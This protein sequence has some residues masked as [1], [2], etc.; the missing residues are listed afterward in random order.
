MATLQEVQTQIAEVYVAT[1]NRAPDAAGL[2]YW[3]NHILN[4]NWTIAQVAK[5]MFQSSEVANTYPSSMNNE[6]FLKAIYNNVLGRDPDEEGLSY[7]LEQ[8][9]NGLSK[10]QM[11]ITVINGA[12]ASTGSESD[13]V[14][15]QNKTD[16][17]KYFAIDLGLD[18][19]Y[20]ARKVVEYITTDSLTLYFS[21]AIAYAL[22]QSEDETFS[23]II[24]TQLNDNLQ[25]TIDV[26]NYIQGS[27][28]N[29]I[30]NAENGSNIIHSLSGIDVV[31]GAE[32]IDVVYAGSGNDVIYGEAGEDFIFGVSGN[33]YL[34]GGLGNDKIYGG[35][36]SDYLYGNEGDDIIYGISGVNYIYGGDGNDHIYGGISNDRIYTGD[37]VNFADAGSGDDLIY[38]GSGIDNIY[39]GIGLDTI[40]ASD[41][42]DILDGQDGN[43]IMYGGLGN[44]MIYGSEGDDIL[45]GN[46]GDDNI[47]GG[48]GADLLN[49]A[50]GIDILSGGAGID[51]FVFASGDSSLTS[52]DTILDFVLGQDLIKLNTQGTNSIISSAVNVSSVSTLALSADL[53]STGDGSSNAIVSWFVFES[54]TYIV[55]DLSADVTFSNATDIIIKL[56]GIYDLSSLDSST[57]L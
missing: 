28:G 45:Y 37:G 54:N 56:Q 50:L 12:K 42:N 30:I 32:G 25:G 46:E 26:S 4:D 52:M 51:T 38:G 11:V 22:S 1:F 49:G 20:T 57:I 36:G 3:A 48:D 31:Y 7:W 43:D 5:S 40:Y 17:A 35:T 14:F 29:D 15:L 21:K 13:R 18:D 33:N 41:G 19:I 55:Q 6:D 23:E 47:N 27:T 9:D 39:G 24:S 10:N 2:E 16:S 53:A 34:H 8:M 44:D